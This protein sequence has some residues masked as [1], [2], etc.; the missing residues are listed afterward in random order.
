VLGKIA[1][2]YGDQ[3]IGSE[4]DYRMKSSIIVFFT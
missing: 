4:E 1:E 3:V 2:P